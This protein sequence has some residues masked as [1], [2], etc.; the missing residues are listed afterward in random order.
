[1]QGEQCSLVTLPAVSPSNECSVCSRTTDTGFLL[2][3]AHLAPSLMTANDLAL[4]DILF[5]LSSRSS[6]W[7]GSFPLHNNPVR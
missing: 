5:I 2:W 1:M 3:E 6:S 7:C 4:Y